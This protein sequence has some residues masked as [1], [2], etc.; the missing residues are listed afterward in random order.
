MAGTLATVGQRITAAFLN[1]NI[2]GAFQ[3]LTLSNSSTGFAV[4]TA[5]VRM[6]NSVTV[7]ISLFFTFTAGSTSG[8]FGGSNG[9]LIGTVPSGMIPAIS[10][11]MPALVT[12]P[13]ALQGYTVDG[14]VNTAGQLH[15]WGQGA[16]VPATATSLS[17]YGFYTIDS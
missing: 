11:Y 14:I 6:F 10:K 8:Y 16:A 3:P 4:T 15:V 5:E 7:E 17:W 9:Q 2:P 13:N 12:A 1:L